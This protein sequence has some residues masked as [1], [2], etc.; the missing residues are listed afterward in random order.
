MGEMCRIRYGETPN[1]LGGA[2][3]I[4]NFDG[5]HR[6]HRVLVDRLRRLAEEVGGPSVVVTFDPPPAKL[7]RPQSVPPALTWMERRAEI[8]F[9]LGID[10]LYV[11]ETT[12]E[13]LQLSPRQ[14]FQQILI[15]QF[16][17]RG[18][19][20]GPNFRFGKDRVGDVELLTELCEQ[21]GVQLSIVGGESEDSEWISSSRIRT[22][23][24]HGDVESANRLLVEPYRIDGMV[25]HGAARGRQLG[26]PT[27]N[28]E[29]SSVLLPPFGVY[30]GRVTREKQSYAAAINIG[31]NPTF[32]EQS[33]KVEVHLIGFDGDL[34]DKKIEV[35]LL[36]RLRD[37]RKFNSIDDLVAQLHRDMAEA[38]QLAEAS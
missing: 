4:G 23:I 11:W 36:K 13:L 24:Q 10:H 22:L 21:Q 12:H 37:I 3:A 32:G 35:E 15:D 31:P 20:E 1:A 28:L 34:Y 25:G 6:G 7:L 33:T 19:V 29:K 18:L 16:Q 30:A 2:I 17:V 26:F 8:L 38:K 5:V 27:A 9:L 14:F